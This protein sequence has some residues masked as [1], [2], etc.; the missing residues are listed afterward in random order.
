M[1]AGQHTQGT[2]MERYGGSEPSSRYLGT[3]DVGSQW[4]NRPIA[5]AGF[6][7]VVEV[8][9]TD[10]TGGLAPAFAGGGGFVGRTNRI[11]DVM[12]MRRLTFV[13]I[14]AMATL[15]LTVGVALAVV[16]TPPFTANA[17]CLAC[18]D[19]TQAGPAFT[20]V[21]F[22]VGAVDR[23]TACAKCHWEPAGAH[24]FHNPSMDCGAC[25]TPGGGAPTPVKWGTPNGVRVPRIST[26][27]GWFYEAASANASA[28]ELH[29]IHLNPR[30]PASVTGPASTLLDGDATPRQCASCHAAAACDAC[31]SSPVGHGD[32]AN[33]LPT[34]SHTAMVDPW[35]GVT[36]YG[37]PTG[38]ETA[39]SAALRAVNCSASGCHSHD[40]FD[41]GERIED[42]D[43][44]I[45]FTGSWSTFW[46]SNYSGGRST[47]AT[48]DG[49]AA[50]SVTGPKT[51]TW[52]G[53][54]DPFTGI[55]EVLVDGV[56]VA[57]VDCYSPATE[58]RA[59]MYTAS[60][61]AGTHTFAVRATGTKNPSSMNNLVYVDAFDIKAPAGPFV[62]T[63]L[64]CHP[65]RTNA[66]GYENVDHEADQALATAPDTAGK[67][68]GSCHAM[69]LLDEHERA[70]SASAG[71]SCGTCHPT[72]RD[73]F[74]AWDQTCAQCHSGQP[75]SAPAP[76]E[77]ADTA[78]TPPA[79]AALCAECHAGLLPA[80]HTGAVSKTDATK[81][82]CNVCHTTT[83]YPATKDC[84]SCHTVFGEHKFA[85]AVETKHTSSW[86]L[87][88]C[89]A[90][91][92]HV[93]N[94][95]WTEHSTRTPSGGG[96]FQC[97]TCHDNGGADSAR[98]K[99]AIAAN[100]TACDACHDGVTQTASHVDRHPAVPPLVD[101][102][103]TPYYSYVNRLTGLP[104]G[105]VTSDCAT[106]HS[107][108]L[109]YEHLGNGARPGRTDSSGQA[110]SCG[111]CHDAPAGSTVSNAIVAGETNCGAC[112]SIHDE[113]P[114]QH[115]STYKD[116][117]EYDCSQC[118][119][120]N[121][122]TVHAGKS[123]SP[124]GRELTGCELC[125]GYYEGARGQ[126]IQYAIEVAND[127]KC[128]ACHSAYHGAASTKHSATSSASVTGCGRC[129][130]NVVDN[131]ISVPT[132]HS[133]VTSPGP[134]TVC[135]NNPVR[136]PDITTKTAECASCHAT[137]GTDY[138]RQQTAKHTYAG[139]TSC[140]AS[141]CHA[142]NSLPE[143]HEPYLSRYPQYADTCALCHLNESPT[144]IDWNT[145][146]ADCSTCHTVHGDINAIH[147]APDSQA[148]V[149]CHETAD[150]RT[151]HATSADPQTS[152]ARCHNATVVLPADTQCVKCHANRSPADP[153]HY[154]AAKHTATEPGDCVDCHYL[155]MKAEHFKTSSGP[156]SCVSCHELKV[157]GFTSAW[158]KTCMAC[159]AAKHGERGT[160]HISTRTDCSG[161]GCHPIGDVS[162]IHDGTPISSSG[163]LPTAGCSF[164][165]S[166]TKMPT[167][168][169][170]GTSGCHPG[171]TGGHHE[172][173]NA[174][175]FIPAG[176]SGCHFT[177]LDDEHLAL[178]LECQTCHASTARQD[179]KNAIAQRN[180]ACVACHP[181]NHYDGAGK[182]YEF[183]PNNASG[184]RVT[185]DL[186]GMRS[187]FV[188]GGSTYSWSLPSA[189]SFLKSGWTTTSIVKCSDCHSYSGATGPHGAQ[190]KVNIDPNYPRAFSTG[191]LQ[192]TSIGMQSDL[193]CAKCHV[194]MTGSSSWS[195]AVH[196]EHD[197]RGMTEGGR[198]VSC[199]VSIPHGW[200]RP[201]MLGSTQDPA[202]YATVSGGLIEFALKSYTPNSWQKSDC[203][204]GCS[205][206]RHPDQSN[207]WPGTAP[208]PPDS[209]TLSGRVTNSSGAGVS[210]ATVSVSGGPS[211]TTNSTGNYTLTVNV[212]SYTVTASA[213]GYTSQ[214]KSATITKNQTTTLD[215][216]MATAPVTTGTIT[217]TV[218]NASNSSAVSGAAVSL[219]NGAST[220][221]ASNG[222]YTLSNV[223]AG[224]Y[225][226]TVTANGFQQ[227]S[228]SV[229]V[230]AGQ[231]T[232]RNVALTPGSVNLALGK[233]F[234]ASRYE[235]SSYSPSKAG[236]DSTSTYWWSDKE[237][238][239]ED[240]EWLRVD[241]GT[242]YRLKK[243]EIVWY[244]QSFAREF[245]IYTSNDGWSW[246][247]VREEND[248]R[249]GGTYTYT[250]DREARYV[251][252]E[253]R[254]TYDDRQT[255][256]AIAELRAF[257]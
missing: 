4:C 162:D 233:T 54:R 17:D 250:F 20:K 99:A 35:T 109:V 100:N 256:Y 174:A 242:R 124:N 144:R 160:K 66:H 220:T 185:S 136:V 236:D 177:Y 43:P 207:P 187:S 178:G 146:S 180:R 37:T 164:C 74:G 93:S 208:M 22:D 122:S 230:T 56:K 123:V 110:L 29:T 120:A 181:S 206:N 217:G 24:P 156:V 72:P 14:A 118:H 91:G 96:A 145:A 132:V 245:R 42:G 188:V 190:M 40:A 55:G 225:T 212:G 209:G 134:C 222:T 182:Y 247:T 197:D 36:G 81:T 215:F 133:D 13:A 71:D 104:R 84:A 31:H 224:T 229:T 57:T 219:S 108:N 139:G 200:A 2:D 92:C 63:C 211:A 214:S 119:S 137:T 18:H 53:V 115:A 6:L 95:L 58:Y 1:S 129:H 49:T 3:W 34:A 94:A 125:H 253:C 170:C 82:S 10:P 33:T 85:G 186:S 153:N 59:F 46:G 26:S 159:H 80:V 249:S 44:R 21:A 168:T 50:I 227:W 112:H 234:T 194:L 244:G 203:Y 148:C 254:R 193:L 202:P 62:P 243:V 68:C 204:A 16:P 105:P 89:V 198:C 221:T 77:A 30:W 101:A 97:V 192:R 61:P 45:T 9:A 241:L 38:N 102:A 127:T 78:H 19:V 76:H 117:P 149:D 210:G 191:L 155:T 173:H 5:P 238:G 218:T 41:P 90:S 195:N 69:T 86:S 126:Q 113:I 141:G 175:T 166:Q 67:T 252:I 116:S 64:S 216:S 201:R 128:T 169:N 189:S 165:H 106:C 88:G 140:V 251:R 130:D 154:D 223:A 73:Q 257:Q 142:S 51:V 151:I 235:S 60:I 239:R 167:S 135:H 121:L 196:K 8:A 138:H 176:C 23:N 199:H 98:Y 183:N 75:D 246:T 25:H 213:V 32:A 83:A 131:A 231:T 47:Y 228:G 28:S 48:S 87:A 70:T 240:R 7:F 255:G 232:T 237:G 150:V 161:S 248:N 147:Q 15:A 65:T 157:D 179:V 152:C 184:H 39:N 107:S 172:Q 158:N 114:F 171:L 226:M 205:S 103:G 143:A 12:Q 163:T 27:A 79:S 11:G 111:T 52:I